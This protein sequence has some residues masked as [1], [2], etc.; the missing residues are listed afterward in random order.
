VVVSGEAAAGAQAGRSA[1]PFLE[2]VV[3][4]TELRHAP[5]TC[6]RSRSCSGSNGVTSTSLG[7]SCV[8]GSSPD[9]VLALGVKGARSVPANLTNP[10]KKRSHDEGPR[11]VDG[12]VNA[13]RA[14]DG[15]EESR[16]H[17]LSHGRGD[18]AER[19]DRGLG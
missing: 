16:W 17:R 8:C 18:R 13:R 11:A 19:R 9:L 4:A 10:L 6:A 1:D 12:G 7:G 3:Y 14:E 15:L 5:R 2:L